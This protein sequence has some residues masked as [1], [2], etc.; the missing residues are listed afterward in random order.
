MTTSCSIPSRAQLRAISA[1]RLPSR[2][3]AS[4]SSTSALN[5]A[6]ARSPAARA[7]GSRRGLHAPVE[8]LVER[9]PALV[10]GRGRDLQQQTDRLQC[11]RVGEIRNEVK[12]AL[13]HEP[14]KP[15]QRPGRHRRRE[16][17]EVPGA[18]RLNGTAAQ[19]ALIRRVERLEAEQLWRRR[20]ADAAEVRCEGLGVAEDRHAVGVTGEHPRLEPVVP[21]D[22]V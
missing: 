14:P 5:A 21:M 22:G 19:D 17:L 15:L 6:R 13:P 9:R 4:H 8:V 1:R 16:G 18:Q 11:E 7:S 12:R 20:H 3:S 2:A 10:L